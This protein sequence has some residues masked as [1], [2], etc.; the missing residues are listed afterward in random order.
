MFKQVSDAH[1]E[2]IGTS[3][4]W[5]TIGYIEKSQPSMSSCYLEKVIVSWMLSTETYDQQPGL[6]FA[7]SRDADLNSGDQD[8]YFITAR[9]A[10][11]PG[12]T[13]TLRADAVIRDNETD[14]KS[15]D[16]R[17]WLHVVATDMDETTSLYTVTE[18]FGRWHT[19]VPQ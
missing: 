12:G 11:G 6:V 5:N 2:N 14:S 16:S 17:I 18:A 4:S 10:R 19:F 1:T 7:L 3:G 15:G 8:G 9:G 13:V